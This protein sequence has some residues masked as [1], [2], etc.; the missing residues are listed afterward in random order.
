M[1]EPKLH[2]KYHG[3]ST[4]EQ[5][6]LEEG[7]KLWLRP[8]FEDL[9]ACIYQTRDEFVRFHQVLVH[10]VIATDIF[11]PDLTKDRLTRWQKAFGPN[12]GAKGGSGPR[13]IALLELLIQAAD[14]SHTMQSWTK[15]IRWNSVLFHEMRR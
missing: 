1:A 13:T 7:W 15:Y 8:E 12:A 9:R 5:N 11:D 4:Q 14:I 10:E 6:S 3:K 2:A